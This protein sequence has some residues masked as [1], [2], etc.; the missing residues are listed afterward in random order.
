[1]NMMML[2]LMSLGA[3][4]LA[5][6]MTAINAAS[7]MDSMLD[8]NSQF[9]NLLDLAGDLEVG[10]FQSQ[11]ASLFL[12]KALASVE[13]HDMSGLRSQKL[14]A[15]QNL[16]MDLPEGEVLEAELP[17][18]DLFTSPAQPENLM[19]QA[20]LGGLQV[21][22]PTPQFPQQTIVGQRPA[23]AVAETALLDDWKLDRIALSTAAPRR[24]V[25]G[26]P[27]LEAVSRWSSAIASGDLKSV[28]IE[29]KE[30]P[31]LPRAEVNPFE[32][33]DEPSVVESGVPRNFER[34]PKSI[35]A[36][37]LARAEKAQPAE[38]PTDIRTLSTKGLPKS[39]P[40][41]HAGSEMLP[42]PQKV[43]SREGFQPAVFSR[44]EATESVAPV[45]KNAAF[46]SPRQEALDS[47]PKSVR[48]FFLDSDT[49]MA[50]GSKSAP[51]MMEAPALRNVEALGEPMDKRISHQAVDHVA[52]KIDALKAQGGGV[53]KVHLDP[54]DLGGL[55]LRV[56]MRSG[57][58]KV[59]IVAEKSETAQLLK[60]SGSE[61]VSRLENSGM[62]TQLSIE[63]GRTG[64]LQGNAG[65]S[66]TLAMTSA[67]L[68]G[69]EPKAPVENVKTEATRPLSSLSSSSG[70]MGGRSR[71]DSGFARDQRREFAREQWSFSRQESA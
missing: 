3:P 39:N 37:E 47:R 1:M 49:A 18:E 15:L 17:V 54:K 16:R 33:S 70:D 30:K 62:Q 5:A 44:A 61:L 25:D 58:A 12:D 4:T 22:K 57:V 10:D 67:D 50:A 6:D 42:Q 2:N 63:H 29:A 48:D 26:A 40:E 46:V 56:S 51:Q 64:S 55:S 36:P 8:G 24:T 13:E 7:E 9:V 19:N 45:Q 65:L 34:D 31:L 32:I 53:V 52:E 41:K 28:S 23:V 14:L 60:N 69:L 68:V 20:S 27:T 66:K 11:D 35:L 71:G 38:M 21:P 43:P 59:E